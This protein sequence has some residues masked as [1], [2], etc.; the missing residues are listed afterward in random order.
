MLNKIIIF[1][2]TCC[3][4]FAFASNTEVICV[5]NQKYIK[6]SDGNNTQII[7]KLVYYSPYEDLVK[8]PNGTRSR[9]II[10][11]YSEIEYC[12]K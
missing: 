9:V 6:Y 11:G 10:Q 7:P 8:N 1:F 2:L 12:N 4:V 5:E 3:I